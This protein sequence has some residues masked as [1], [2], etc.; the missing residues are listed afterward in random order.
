MENMALIPAPS[1]VDDE[2]CEISTDNPFFP[3]ITKD[4]PIPSRPVPKI[5]K[6][7]LFP[8]P[9]TFIETP[10]KTKSNQ[11][12]TSTPL[13]TTTV[14]INQSTLVS[15]VSPKHTLFTPELKEM[16]I[17]TPRR[18]KKTPLVNFSLFEEKA[19]IK[20]KNVKFVPQVS[21]KTAEVL[22]EIIPES[23]LP[24]KYSLMKNKFKTN[25]NHYKNQMQDLEAQISVKLQV[26]FNES[27]E[28]MLVIES[29]S[30][31]IEFLNDGNREEYIILKK[32]VGLCS[33]LKKAFSFVDPS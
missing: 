13:P 17:E 33:K 21:S 9:S 14:M 28:R 7:P 16:S 11:I 1:V 3:K 10:E 30:G 5:L 32:K 15:E 25:P 18:K 26:M 27:W 23:D 31:S 24:E 4:T 6:A 2:G 22:K 8:P 19:A 29:S 20:E 12:K